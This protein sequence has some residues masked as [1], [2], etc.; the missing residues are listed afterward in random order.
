[1]QLLNLLNQSIKLKLKI[2]TKILQ[3][4]GKY[5]KFIKFIVVD[6]AELLM[7]KK[8][9]PEQLCKHIRQ[10]STLLKFFIPIVSEILIIFQS[11]KSLKVKYNL[12]HIEW[13]IDY[14]ISFKKY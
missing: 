1:M 4:Q 8:R 9:L 6:F 2:Q 10:I 13:D 11:W 7:I 12:A 14:Y 5:L 3:S